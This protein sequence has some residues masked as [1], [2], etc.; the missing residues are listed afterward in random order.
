[1]GFICLFLIR[2]LSAL[3]PGEPESEHKKTEFRDRVFAEP[4]EVTPGKE[5]FKGLLQNGVTSDFR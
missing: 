5:I 4:F 2:N 3:F 1:M